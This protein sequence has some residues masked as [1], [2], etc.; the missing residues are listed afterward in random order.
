[1]QAAEHWHMNCLGRS[2][3]A[4][5]HAVHLKRVGQQIL[6]NFLTRRLRAAWNAW[7]DMIQVN[8]RDCASD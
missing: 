4:L 8:H 5:Q 1:M 2:M 7:T 6:A 3:A